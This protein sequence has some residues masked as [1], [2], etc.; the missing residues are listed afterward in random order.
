VADD[1][2]IVDDSRDRTLGTH[3]GRGTKAADGMRPEL[4]VDVDEA[5]D[6]RTLGTH[7]GRVVRAADRGPD[8]FGV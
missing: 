4:A 8:L 2:E 5:I 1:D 3:E 7:E 6:D